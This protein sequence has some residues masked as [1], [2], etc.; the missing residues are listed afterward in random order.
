MI[1]M[2]QNLKLMNKGIVFERAETLIAEPKPIRV[3]SGAVAVCF[4]P[5][6]IKSQEMEMIVTSS[7]HI[8]KNMNA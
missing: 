1:C 5:R 7:S 8:E 2:L 3:S 4:F 6:G